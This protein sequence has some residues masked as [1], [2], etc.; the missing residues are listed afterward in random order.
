MSSEERMSRYYI[1]LQTEDS[2]G[3]LSQ[4][5]GVLGMRKISIASV[6][7]K[8]VNAGYV[9]LIIVTHEAVESE[10]LKCIE[11]IEKFPFVKERA[12][13]IPVEDFK[14]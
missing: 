4:I 11:D 10:L 8:E 12:I 2:P 3:I 9:P 1:R 14:N 13:V 5:S 6:I 7:Q